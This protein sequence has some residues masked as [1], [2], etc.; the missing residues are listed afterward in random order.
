MRDEE[1]VMGEGVMSEGK[2]SL[3]GSLDDTRCRERAL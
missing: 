1:G 3:H 2:G